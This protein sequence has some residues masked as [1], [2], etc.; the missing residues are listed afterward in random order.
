VK[1]GIRHTFATMAISKKMDAKSLSIT[2]GHTDVGFTMKRYI[3]P[4]IEHRRSQ[5]EKIAVEF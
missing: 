1:V 2:L 5:I 3:H 4:S